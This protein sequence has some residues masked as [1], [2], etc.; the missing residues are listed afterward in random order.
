[1]FGVSIKSGTSQAGLVE[2]L[3]Y[4]LGTGKVGQ[5]HHVVNKQPE[6][7]PETS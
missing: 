2:N 1:M 7:E 4:G 5:Y 6:P 3:S